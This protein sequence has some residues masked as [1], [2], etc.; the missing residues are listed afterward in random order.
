[1][2]HT[3]PPITPPSFDDDFAS[4]YRSL[5]LPA[6]FHFRSD[7]LP[8]SL[9]FPCSLR[10]MKQDAHKSSLQLAPPLHSRHLQSL[11]SSQQSTKSSIA[12]PLSHTPVPMQLYNTS[13][14]KPVVEGSYQQYKNSSSS[15]SSN[16]TQCQS[17]NLITSQTT[18]A[19]VITTAPCRP[20]LCTLNTPG[21]GTLPLSPRPRIAGSVAGSA[22]LPKLSTA[23]VLAPAASS[24]RAHSS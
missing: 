15:S 14:A 23:H 4:K 17:R 3:A 10:L 18:A 11:A 7:T 13:V 16:A 24:S 1:M 22:R 5:P 21:V 12:L 8:F 19:G 2:S 20:S 9:K 6:S